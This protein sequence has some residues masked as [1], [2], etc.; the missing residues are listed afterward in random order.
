MSKRRIDDVIDQVLELVPEDEKTFRVRLER[1]QFN[2][3]FV[4]PEIRGKCWREGQAVM[5]EHLPHDPSKLN[6]WQRKVVAIWKGEP[7]GD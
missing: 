1:V 7:D 4:A 5:L 2:A 6:D 3:G